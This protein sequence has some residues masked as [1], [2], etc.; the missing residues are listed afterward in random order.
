[1]KRLFIFCVIILAI[2]AGCT[3]SDN[4]ELISQY[5]VTIQE[6]EYDLSN[7][8]T[9]IIDF[10]KVISNNEV[11]IEELNND[12]DELNVILDQYF[13]SSIEEVT[14]NENTEERINNSISMLVDALNYHYSDRLLEMKDLLL[15]DYAYAESIVAA[16]DDYKT[17]FFEGEITWYEVQLSEVYLGQYEYIL[18]NDFDA[19]VT[20]LIAIEDDKV[21]IKDHLISYSYDKNRYMDSF[22]R[23]LTDR[24]AT[25]LGLRFAYDFGYEESVFTDLGNYII[26]IYETEFDLETLNWEFTGSIDEYGD[27]SC[28]IYGYKDS[29]YTEHQI[30]VSAMDG[31]VGIDD[32]WID[33]EAFG[34]Q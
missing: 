30:R 1:M 24:S 21:V 16:F 5:E 34:L 8:E 14:V 4:A 29:V 9:T 28:K 33:L 17:I 31:L 15:L 22:M 26:G 25:D 6:L 2:T 13:N 11:Q 20:G 18:G 27:F 23:Y 3:S 19:N 7:K 10:E 12:V 32:S